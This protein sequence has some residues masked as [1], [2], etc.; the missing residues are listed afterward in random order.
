MKL[1]Q[2][3]LRNTFGKY[4]SVFLVSV[5][6]ALYYPQKLQTT[7]ILVPFRVFI[8]LFVYN[9]AFSY[10]GSSINGI[11]V[12]IAIW[13]I[14]VYHILLYAQ[15]RNIFRTINQEIKLG[16]FETQLNKPYSYLFYKLWEQF[17]RGVLSFIISLVVVVPLLYIATNGLPQTFDSL[18]A[19]GALSLAIGGTLVSAALYIVTSLPALWFD[20]A[21]PFYWIVDKAILILGG[22][23]IPLALLP[24]NFQL[25]AR[26]TPFG[27]PMF[28][29]YMFNPNFTEEWLSLLIVQIAWIIVLYLVA[30]FLFS[31][32]QQR[33][34]INGG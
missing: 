27:A 21:D 14:A 13:S 9:Y 25:L 11:N 19:I 5:K 20:D 32:A 7:M 10:L 16:S 24:E 8:L 23:Y 4:F 33:L 1:K 18:R 15:F 17:G 34:S 3:N 2:A 31:K 29:T 30:V 12:H 22:S 26:V 6:E 28:A